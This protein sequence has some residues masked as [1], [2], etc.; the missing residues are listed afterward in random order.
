[1]KVEGEGFSLYNTREELAKDLLEEGKKMVSQGNYQKAYDNFSDAMIHLKCFKEAYFHRSVVKFIWKDY[2]GGLAD[3]A[4]ALK[5]DPDYADAWAQNGFVKTE[6][7][8]FDEALKDYFRALALDPLNAHYFNDR[9]YLRKQMN[10]FIGAMEDY[11]QSIKLK[12]EAYDAYFNRAKLKFKLDDPVG[13]K[14]DLT[15]AA[16][17]GFMPAIMQLK[18]ME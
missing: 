15:K 2:E 8:R 10:D 12:P 5:I 4:E 13:C 7:C 9:G 3:L 17:L 1:M 14:E 16:E 6:L 11:T 18:R